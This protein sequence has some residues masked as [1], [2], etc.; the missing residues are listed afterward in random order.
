M[1]A[2][3]SSSPPF[4]FY[5][6]AFVAFW[7]ITAA[8]CG[9]AIGWTFVVTSFGIRGQLGVRLM[10]VVSWPSVHSFN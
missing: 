10:V 1:A 6:L 8:V 4:R 2:K 3:F 7:C 9:L 5:W